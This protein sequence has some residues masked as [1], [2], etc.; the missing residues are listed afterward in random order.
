MHAAQNLPPHED[1]GYE[2][3]F[4]KPSEINKIWASEKPIDDLI[5]LVSRL[6][7]IYNYDENYNEYEKR[8][9]HDEQ[10]L[11]AEFSLQNLVYFKSDMKIDDT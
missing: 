8:F 7:L 11:L 4:I 3:I 10:R 2:Q 1:A 5:P 9:D 6:S